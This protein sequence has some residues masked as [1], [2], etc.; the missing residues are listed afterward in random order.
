MGR[1]RGTYGEEHKDDKRYQRNM[2]KA[3]NK[4]RRN[5]RFAVKAAFHGINWNAYTHHG[6]YDM[7]MTANPKAMGQRAQAWSELARE[8]ERTTGEVQRSVD[9]LLKTWRGAA[10]VSAAGSNTE[11]AGWADEM[12]HRT[13]GIAAG[14]VQYT[15]AVEEAQKRMPPPEFAS[16]EK[17]LR[18]GYDVIA[19][20]GP[21]SAYLV[22]ALVDDQKPDADKAN[23]A[24]AEAVRVMQ[25]YGTQSQQ[26]HDEMP[27]FYEAPPTANG[28][29]D[30]EPI[31]GGDGGG[32][33]TGGGTSPRPLPAQPG[34]GVLGDTD[35]DGIPDSTTAESFTPGTSGPGGPGGPGYGGGT[36]YGGL[37]GGGYGS[38]GDATRGGPGG[39][40]FGGGGG[41]AAGAA[42]LAA[43]GAGGAG[44]PGAAG[45][46][47]AR[48]GGALGGAGGMYPGMAGAGMPGE[49]DKEH[50]NK[51]DNGLDLFDDLP[52]AY[53]PVFG[54]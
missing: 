51:Y 35:G 1:D 44:G 10:A 48:G 17:L 13:T 26:V 5:E 18:Q 34:P 30:S 4:R 11:L 16:A 23:A 28:A 42:P 14:L 46:A 53:P 40:G 8:I 12:S 36:G 47:G 25:T 3:R 39:L 9:R 33:D 45:L 38:G 15:E 43:R 31:G 21:S 29:P 52:P 49:E 19:T 7:I 50:T 27:Y 22:Q 24:K 41:G 54:A 2:A 37:P 6:L 20:G 32:G